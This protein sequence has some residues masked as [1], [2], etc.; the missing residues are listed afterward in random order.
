MSRLVDLGATPIVRGGRVVGVRFE[1][2][3]DDGAGPHPEGHAIC[4]L[5]AN[6]PDGGPTHPDDPSCPGNNDGNRWTRS[7]AGLA[8]LTLSP[9]VDCSRSSSCPYHGVVTDGRA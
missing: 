8:D 3:Y 4:V 2:P 7:G 5:Y 1:C 6:P 9:S